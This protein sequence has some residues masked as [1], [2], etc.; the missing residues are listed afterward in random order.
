MHGKS[1]VL[2]YTISANFVLNDITYCSQS[3]ILTHVWV[4]E[5]ISAPYYEFLHIP[6]HTS[7]AAI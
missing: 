5:S 6:F 3:L 2:A 4:R 7:E 1:N